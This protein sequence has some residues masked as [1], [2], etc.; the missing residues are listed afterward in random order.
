LAERRL[1]EQE[2]LLELG[3]DVLRPARPNHDRVVAAEDVDGALVLPI[4]VERLLSAERARPRALDVLRLAELRV[5]QRQPIDARHRRRAGAQE[6]VPAPLDLEPPARVEPAERDPPQR[7]GQR[8]A[9]TRRR[10][11][12]A[13]ARRGL[14]LP[15]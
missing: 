3:D 15:E 8:R 9:E 4:D 2:A 10:A 12:L 7:V 11:L 14:A 13:L 6:Q 1:A 5:V